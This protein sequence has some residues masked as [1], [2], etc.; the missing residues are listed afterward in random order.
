MLWFSTV[1]RGFQGSYIQRSFKAIQQVSQGL[2]GADNGSRVEEISEGFK[3][4]SGGLGM[5]FDGFRGLLK[6]LQGCFR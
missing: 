1:S 4:V 2:Q 5:V 6:E 3:G